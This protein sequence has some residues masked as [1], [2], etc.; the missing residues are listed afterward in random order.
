MKKKFIKYLITS[1]ILTGFTVSADTHI[2]CASSNY[3]NTKYDIQK[4]MEESALF[5][6][7]D[8]QRFI[9]KTEYAFDGNETEVK[10]NNDGSI[11]VYITNGSNNKN[12]QVGNTLYAY[13]IAMTYGVTE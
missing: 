1:L 11:T 7:H 10:V 8:I 2:S 6:E 4:I 9:E 3:Q 5:D 12:Y 13:P